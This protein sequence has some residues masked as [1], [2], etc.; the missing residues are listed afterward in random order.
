[1]KELYTSHEVQ[2]ACKISR[3]RLSQLREYLDE[4]DYTVLSKTQIVY[5]KSA[6]LKIQARQRKNKRFKNRLL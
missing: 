1:M 2:E 3:T 4:N 6:I 5:R